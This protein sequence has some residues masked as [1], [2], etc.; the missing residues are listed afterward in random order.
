M[1]DLSLGQIG[2]IAFSLYCAATFTTNLDRI[3]R[4]GLHWR[5]PAIG[6]VSSAG[7]VLALL[8]SFMLARALTNI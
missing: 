8:L 6:I 2:V 3:L 7:F 1:Y 5:E 4:S